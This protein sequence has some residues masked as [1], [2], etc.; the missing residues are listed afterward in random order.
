MTC[1]D[2]EAAKSAKE[3]MLGSSSY[4]EFALKLEL[5][6]LEMRSVPVLKAVYGAV[7]DAATRRR[8]E[9]DVAPMMKGGALEDYALDIVGMSARNPRYRHTKFDSWLARIW[10]RENRDFGRV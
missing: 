2:R 9:A 7:R 6:G 1:T 10:L 3:A 8:L 4:E 5:M